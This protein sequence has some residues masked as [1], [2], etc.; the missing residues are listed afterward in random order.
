MSDVPFCTACNY[1]LAFNW[2]LA[3]LATWREHL[4][5]VKMAVKPQSLIRPIFGFKTLHVFVGGMRVEEW[6]VIATLSGLNAGYAFFMLIGRLRIKGNAFEVLT[7]MVAEKTLRV[8]ANTG[9][10]D[11]AAGDRE[12]TLFA[13]GAAANGCGCPVRA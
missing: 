11:D 12:R 8:E 5:E 4:V 6:Y 3:A 13:Q 9:S 1:N 10:G 7:T 2:R